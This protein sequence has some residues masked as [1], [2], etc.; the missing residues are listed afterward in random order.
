M[1]NATLGTSAKAAQVLAGILAV[2]SPV[3]ACEFP[4]SLE[5]YARPVQKATSHI[6]FA[7]PTSNATSIFA[8]QG[9]YS[10]AAYVDAA[11]STV[12]L[13]RLTTQHEKLIGEIRS[14]SLLSADWD[15]EGAL[16]P[17]A[18]SIKESV[19]FSRLLSDV[20]LPEP[21]L[22]ASGHVSL[23]KNDS[24]LYADIEFLGDGR[25]AYFIKRNGDKH[26]GVLT[27]DSQKMPAVFSALL[28]A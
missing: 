16:A 6:P 8:G 11:E 18:Q 19:S 9:Q 25:I 14:W 12:P 17:S 7:L 20:S 4:K 21:M 26:K 27:F 10:D 3:S 28:A 5:L 2:S 15:G 24:D 23:Y 22:L 1:H 13:E